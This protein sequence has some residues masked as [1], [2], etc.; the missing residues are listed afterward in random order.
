MNE[1]EP[2]A[3]G[4]ALLTLGG[5]LRRAEVSPDGR[6]LHQ[7]GGRG[8]RAYQ[9]ARGNGGLVRVSW[10]ETVELT[11]AGRVGRWSGE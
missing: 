3:A 4:R 5:L 8:R 6:T 9:R 10:D 1:P 2:S 7:V 11:A